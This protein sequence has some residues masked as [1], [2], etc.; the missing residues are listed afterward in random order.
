[1]KKVNVVYVMSESFIDP[2]LG[3]HLT[4]LRK[5]RANPLHKRNSKI[6]K[7]RLGGI[8][9]IW[10]RNGK[11]WIWS[12]YWIKQLLPKLNSYTSIVPSNKD[13]PSIVKNF[14]ENGYKTLAMHPYNRNMYRRETV[15][16]N[17]GF[18][19]YKSIESLKIL[20]N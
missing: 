12:T 16:P 8:K 14:N 2:A 11:R 18:Q 4:W 13:T 20:L 1:M 10:W 19:E 7:F 9:R 5:Y 17:L 15:Y 6:T 3:K